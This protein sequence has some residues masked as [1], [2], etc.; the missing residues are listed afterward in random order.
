MDKKYLQYQ[1]LDFAQD[2]DFIHWVRR[3]DKANPVF[4]EAWQQAHP[5]KA[6]V[7]QEARLLV[8]AIRIQ[9][10][11]PSLGQIDQLWQK[12]DVATPVQNA[13]VHSMGWRKYIAL[14]AS[15]VGIAIAL[16]V[17][18]QNQNV[19]IAANRG[20]RIEHALPDGSKITLNAASKI[21]YNPK[22]WSKERLVELEGE[23]FFEVEKGAIFKVLHPKGTVEVLGT[24]FN[25]NTKDERFEVAC[26]TG[27][28]SVAI[29]NVTTPY[30]LTPNKILRVANAAAA[31]DTSS[32]DAS[33][34]GSWRNGLFIFEKNNFEV[35]IA[36]LEQQY[37]I[38]IQYPQNMDSDM[39]IEFFF[40]L[41]HPIDSALNLLQDM[42]GVRWS[43]SGKVI[44]IE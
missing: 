38:D 6:L 15:L 42:K 37:D 29:E 32:F 44:I 17:W 25:I 31:V 28:V 26:F 43:K 16:F 40:D 35:I 9:E 14:A 36:A 18:H 19:I 21:N 22:T 33:K 13:K 10:M 7:L 20:E 8:N 39:P 2:D 4:W 11:E 23:A 30:L 24:S 41:K 5:E 27:K 1:A 34:V 12:I 3:T